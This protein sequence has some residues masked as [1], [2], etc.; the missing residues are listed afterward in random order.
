MT[1]PVYGTLPATYDMYKRCGFLNSPLILVTAFGC[2][3]TSQF[4]IMTSY[5]RN[6]AKDYKDAAFIDGANDFTAF[7]LVMFPQSIGIVVTYIVMQFIASWNDYF[8]TMLYLDKMPTLASGLFTYQTIVERT[9]NYP[10]FFAGI[11]ITAIPTIILYIP[12][13]NLMIKNLSFG[14]LKG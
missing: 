1:L 3:G 11:V 8:A 5:Y 10:L 14:G 12:L 2:F 7:F 4:L 9:G 13:H 6:L